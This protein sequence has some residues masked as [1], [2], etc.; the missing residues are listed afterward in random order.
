MPVE[1]WLAV[2][3]PNEVPGVIGCRESDAVGILRDR[4]LRDGEIRFR[5]S[6]EPRGVVLDQAPAAGR[7]VNA[8]TPIALWIATSQRITVPDVRGRDQRAATDML[9]TAGLVVG[10]VREREH[11][12]TRGTVI[13]Q[14]PAP[15][16]QVDAGTAVS[17]SIAVP[18][19][20]VVITLPAPSPPS[21]QPRPVRVPA[22]VGVPLQEAFALLQNAGFRPGRISEIRSVDKVTAG[23]VTAQ[24]PAAGTDAPPGATVDL[25]VPASYGAPFGPGMGTFWAI[26]ISA[27]VLLMAWVSTAR[28]L[29][30]RTRSPRPASDSLPSDALLDENV[31]FTVHCPREIMIDQWYQLLLFAH[32]SGPPGRDPHAPDPV[33]EMRREA[34]QV[35]AERKHDYR[36]VTQD[37]V[38]AVPRHGN[39][40][41][42]PVMDGIEFNPTER[43]FRWE[44][45]L[46]RE[47]FQIRAL[48]GSI[49]R[50]AR[51]RLTVFY[52]RLIIGEVPLAI[53]VVHALS[54]ASDRAVTEVNG[55][56]YRRIFASYSRQDTAMVEEFE[57]LVEALGDRYL[58]DVRDVRSGEQWSSRLEELMR[59]ADVFQL[60]WSWNSL[61]SRFVR[62]E[63]EFALGLQRPFFVRPVYWESP[64]PE[65]TD[66]PPQSLRVLGFHKLRTP[67]ESSA[68]PPRPNRLERARIPVRRLALSG[69]LAVVILV[70]GFLSAIAIPGLLRSR[71]SANEARALEALRAM[72][73]AQSAY[74]AAAEGVYGRPDCLRSPADCIP[75]YQGEPFL[76]RYSVSTGTIS[77]Y[78]FS[79]DGIKAM[80]T[81]GRQVS[82]YSA[83]V[84]TAVPVNPGVTGK[85]TFCTDQTRRLCVWKD[86]AMPRVVDG[87]CDSG[88][89]QLQ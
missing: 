26:A 88:C 6:A 41:L 57:R 76:P 15:G 42:V 21:V 29:S 81:S 40:T 51:G 64:F 37:A 33:E 7:R 11:R 8:E 63:W 4:P 70:V 82:G 85:K 66:L 34:A 68:E 23:T 3:I 10:D 16:V 53:P 54:T 83:W 38:E 79:F 84:Y 59:T 35:L 20:P 60:F 77:G 30:R 25:V 39:L 47:E 50:T 18:L 65:T 36:S 80:Q 87:R 49:P 44:Q 14:Q 46:H 24:F 75:S 69:K 13:D 71:I 58:R 9:R 43:S 74:A 1:V 52:G 61:G 27:I 72:S 86:G 32:L 22:V 31:Q 56:A 55:R 45:S 19:P 2:P 48:S 73:S 17:L 67:T 62:Q 5:E 12:T 28:R 78:V 89:E